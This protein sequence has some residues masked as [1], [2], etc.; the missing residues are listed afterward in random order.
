MEILHTLDTMGAELLAE[1]LDFYETELA[2]GDYSLPYQQQCL[3]RISEL[4]HWKSEKNAPK[5]KAQPN[6]Q[7]PPPNDAFSK[8]M[9]QA[10]YEWTPP[11]VSRNILVHEST[12]QSST[13]TNTSKTESE[14]FQVIS[15]DILK[16]RTLD[17]YKTTFK[18]FLVNETPI[19]QEMLEKHLDFFLPWELQMIVQTLPLEETFLE[20]H[21]AVLEKGAISQYQLFSEKFF[22]KHFGDLWPEVVLKKGKNPWRQQG[23]RSKQL[24]VFLRLRGVKA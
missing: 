15:S 3:A 4:R 20:N 11:A 13:G 16:M 5:E 7:A 24:D 1:D 18:Q 17:N 21:F 12:L 19:T 9:E 23:K 10:G 14:I 2:T 8:Q 6:H 22:M